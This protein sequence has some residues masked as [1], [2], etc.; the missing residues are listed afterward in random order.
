MMTLEEKA[1]A[2]DTLA[3]MLLVPAD[4]VSRD[5]TMIALNQLIDERAEARCDREEFAMDI[6][7][8]AKARFMRCVSL[9]QYE[10]SLTIGRLYRCIGEESGMLRILDNSADDGEPGSLDGY[11]MEKELFVEEPA[12][13]ALEDAQREIERCHAVL[14][15]IYDDLCALETTLKHEQLLLC[16]VDLCKHWKHPE[17]EMKSRF[18][19]EEGR[20]E[21]RSVHRARARLLQEWVEKSG[22]DP[23][24]L[25]TWLGDEEE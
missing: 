3:H 23:R 4:L 18:A 1:A 14:G 2:F 16:P 13:V 25:K 20:A 5:A 7:R 10:G 11:L 6:A 15:V 24:H 8:Y 12:T 9:G 21:A 19:T 22:G 17:W